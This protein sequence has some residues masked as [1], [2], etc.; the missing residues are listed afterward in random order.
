M[1]ESTVYVL[2]GEKRS[3]FMNDVAKIDVCGKNFFCQDILGEGKI[4]EG[5]VLA[6]INL[7]GHEII[8]ENAR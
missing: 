8:F 1:C 4:L 3:M 2:K 7:V 6:G 5:V